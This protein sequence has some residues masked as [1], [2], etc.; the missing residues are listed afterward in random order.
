MRLYKKLRHSYWLL[1]EF[2]RKHISLLVIS[3]IGTFLVIVFFLN[4][5]PFF[6]SILF[7]Q[8]HIIGLIGQFSPRE[9]PDELA[10]Q[11]SNP[12]ITIDQNGDIQPL[13]AYSWEV[14]N[15]GKTYRFHLRNDLYW[16][17][18]KPFKAYDLHYSFQDVKVIPVDDYTI[19]FV[20]QKPLNIFPI[21]LTQPVIKLPLTGVG[22]LYSVNTYKLR[23]G[24]LV[25]ISLSPNKPG[26]PFKVYRFYDSEDDLIT[27]YKKGEITYFT[28]PDRN[29][30]ESFADWNNTH[31]KKNIDYTKVMAL[32]MNTQSGPLIERDVRKALAYGTPSY[33][34]LG[35]PARGPIPPASW[36]Y[37]EDVKAYPYNEERAKSLL[38]KNLSASDSAKLTMYT[39]F[40]YISLGEDLKKKYADIGLDVDLKVVST[41]PTEYDLFLTVWNPPTDPDQY[42]FWHSTQEGTNIT[43]FKNLKI[44]K[45]L[46]DGRRV[47]NVKQRQAIY[48]DFQKNIA[49]EVPA[50]FMYHP[51]EYVITRK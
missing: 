21:Y 14:L 38:E 9:I 23:K 22:S 39:F 11:I 47:V 30:A 48:T 2:M 40:D 15:Q 24:Q 46:E 12:L 7:Q 3:F 5:F 50:Y 6:N 20:L 42:F 28:T 18:K 10:R 4:F 34:E 41:P 31:I 45:L 26:L 51:Y 36:A 8:K 16:S 27:A 37:Y 44:D 35:E 29:I 17:D 43:K 32:F 25:S 13:L 19:D 33:P 1:T 49:E